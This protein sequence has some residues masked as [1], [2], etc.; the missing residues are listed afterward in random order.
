MLA[1][2]GWPLLNSPQ[3]GAI[4]RWLKKILAEFEKEDPKIFTKGRYTARYMK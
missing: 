2:Y 1:I 4:K 3:R